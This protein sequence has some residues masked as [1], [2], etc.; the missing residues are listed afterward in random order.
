MKMERILPLFFVG[1]FSIFIVMYLF[2]EKE[3]E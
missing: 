1:V 3:H 2:R